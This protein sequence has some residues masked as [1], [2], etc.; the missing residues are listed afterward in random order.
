MGV[1]LLNLEVISFEMQS[2]P[3]DRNY[4]VF[5]VLCLIGLFS[6][7]ADRLNASLQSSSR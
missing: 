7:A 6:L 5:E 4:A 3:G 1:D 2:D